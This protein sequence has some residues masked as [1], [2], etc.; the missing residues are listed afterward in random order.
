MAKPKIIRK[1]FSP[2]KKDEIP[3]FLSEMQK[4]ETAKSF[5]IQ[6]STVC[7]IFKN[8]SLFVKVYLP[9]KSQIHKGFEGEKTGR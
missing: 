9:V 6:D 5:Q 2:Q 8:F 3:G 1:R 7:K 4:L